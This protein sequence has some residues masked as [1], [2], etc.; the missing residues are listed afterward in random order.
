MTE[1][2]TTI[3]SI[4]TIIA[5]ILVLGIVLAI[6]LRKK[7]EWARKVLKIASNNA[8]PGSFGV[9][10]LSML[11]SL[12]YSDVAHYEPCVLCWYQRIFMYP[13]V[14]LFYIAFI[15]KEKIIYPY[16][17]AMASVGGAIALYH[18]L[19]QIGVTD[20]APCKAVGYSVSCTEYFSLNFGYI[21]IPMMAFS[22]FALILALRY[23][24]KFVDN[25]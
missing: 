4:L 11:G 23:T 5:D 2:A 24:E 14:L 6:F 18:Y 13:L 20:I 9:A 17:T 19:L 8:I 22:A 21:T 1:T 3:L 10:L 15:R 25:K 12:F 7:H 16:T